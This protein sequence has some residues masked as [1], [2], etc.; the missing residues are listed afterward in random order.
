MH[1]PWDCP[2][3]IKIAILRYLGYLKSTGACPGACRRLCLSCDGAIRLA[4]APFGP[5][6]SA[7]CAAAAM[8]IQSICPGRMQM[9]PSR[10]LSGD[11]YC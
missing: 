1:V 8:N 2:E 10:D 5:A 6:S 9:D 4:S 7:P 11:S 3:Y